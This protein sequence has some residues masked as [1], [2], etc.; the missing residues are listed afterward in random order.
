[1]INEKYIGRSNTFFFD[2]GRIRR[3][4]ASIEKKSCS[5]DLCLCLMMK[6]YGYAIKS[7]IIIINSHLSVSENNYQDKF[8]KKAPWKCTVVI[9]KDIIFFLRKTLNS[10]G[11]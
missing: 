2:R 5:I 1:M 4:L 11:Y 6:N 8:Q 7:I 9:N 3:M 10:Y